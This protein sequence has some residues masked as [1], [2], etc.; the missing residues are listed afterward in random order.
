MS[1]FDG[2]YPIPIG[3]AAKTFSKISV[4]KTHPKKKQHAA[5]RVKALA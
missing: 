3:K 1:C 5:A 4:S 2:I